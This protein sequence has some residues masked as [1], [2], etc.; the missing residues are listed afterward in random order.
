MI[1]IVKSDVLRIKCRRVFLNLKN[2]RKHYINYIEDKFIHETT[3]YYI[4]EQIYMGFTF[5]PI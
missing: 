3:K 1:V 2:N 5:T 4:Y